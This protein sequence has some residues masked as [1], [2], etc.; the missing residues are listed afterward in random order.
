MP[1]VQIIVCSVDAPLTGPAGARQSL[2]AIAG[3]LAEQPVP[4]GQPGNGEPTCPIVPLSAEDHCAEAVACLCEA[5]TDRAR[6]FHH[7]ADRDRYVL[8]HGLLRGLLARRLDRPPATL[9][10]HAGINGKPE[11]RDAAMDIHFNLSYGWR[12]FAVAIAPEPV[13]VDLERLRGNL[14]VQALGRRL[15]TGEEMD[16]LAGAGPAEM[17]QRF[18][19]L[20]TRKEAV[21][22]AAG[23]SLDAM[24]E[25][26][27]LAD[28]ALIDVPGQGRR[29]FQVK[30]L[31]APPG[32]DLAVA[33]T[34]ADP[35]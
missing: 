8:A 12:H 22:K 25:F 33:L 29:A 17:Q 14:D 20:W 15:F 4:E 13:G 21:L 11:L 26:H 27:V 30:N 34:G 24:P 9:Q 32:H 7:Q 2:D 16:F 10:I 19:R 28:D 18:F 31:P 5:E 1:P 23:S 6:R 3:R 35:G